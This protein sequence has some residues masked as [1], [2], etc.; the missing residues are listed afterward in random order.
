MTQCL[1]QCFAARDRMPFSL[2]LFTLFE[3][4]CTDLTLHCIGII[5]SLRHMK[6]HSLRCHEML[7]CRAAAPYR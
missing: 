7:M 6:L 5:Y 1:T 3:R 2:Q 4:M